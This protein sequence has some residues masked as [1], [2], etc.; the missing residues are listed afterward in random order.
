MD[1]FFHRDI[2][3]AEFTLEESEGRH[4]AQVLRKE[5]GELVEVFDGQGASTA[6][7]I[8][9]IGKKGGNVVLARITDV[10]ADPVPTPA[11]CVAAAVP[12]GERFKWMIEKLTEIGVDELQLLSTRRSVAEPGAD[13][14]DKLTALVIAACKQ[15]RR[16]HLLKIH[17]VVPWS[18]FL[19]SPG[20]DLFLCNA[21][22]SSPINAPISA[23]ASRLI[24][25]VGPEGGWTPEEVD[26]CS[27]CASFR[28]MIALSSHILRVET[29]AILSGAW[30]A[31]RRAVSKLPGGVMAPDQ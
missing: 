3:P 30:A 1:R 12:K 31:Q 21:D 24:V 18:Q 19:K 2:V 16:N 22:G 6:A 15:A 29:A 23:D 10:V 13:R 7:R 26:E 9:A 14:V 5:V 28:G 25:A 4:L 8:A 20:G 27:R 11:V 17:P